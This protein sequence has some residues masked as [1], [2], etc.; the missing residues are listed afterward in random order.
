[1]KYADINTNSNLISIWINK[2][3]R[4]R[5]IPMTS[6]VGRIL[7]SRKSSNP[8]KPFT[9][10]KYQAER[11]WNWARKDMGFGTDKEFVLHALRHSCA[12]RMV[13][14]GVDLYVVKE[15]LGHSSIQVTEKYAHLN[16]AKLVQAVEAL[17]VDILKEI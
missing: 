16:P 11:A 17:E 8:E 10:D 5:S 14:A 7:V 1:L 13:N 15:W 4:P 9:I 6:R 12:S 2:G 3:E